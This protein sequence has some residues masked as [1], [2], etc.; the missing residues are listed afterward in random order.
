MSDKLRCDEQESV[1]GYAFVVLFL[2][3]V[4]LFTDMCSVFCHSKLHLLHIIIEFVYRSNTHARKV[5]GFVCVHNKTSVCLFSV[6]FD[7]D[8]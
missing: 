4:S 5:L 7:T 3:L 2:F 1:H 8:A 6:S